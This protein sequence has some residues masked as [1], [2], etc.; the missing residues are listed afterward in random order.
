MDLF[1]IDDPFSSLDVHVSSK[2]FDNLRKFL[3]N[4]TT[5]ICTIN[6]REFMS[7]VDRIILLENGCVKK[8]GKPN[9]ILNDINENQLSSKLSTD[10]NKK[11]LQEILNLDQLDNDEFKEELSKGRVKMKVYSTYLRAVG[12]SMAIC[13]ILFVLLMQTSKSS[14]DYWLSYWVDRLKID[15]DEN[16]FFYLKVFLII[17]IITNVFAAFRSVLFAIGC[18][19][20]AKNLYIRL[21]NVIV[22]SKI[23][24][25][26]SRTYGQIINRLNSDVYH[27]DENLPFTLNL[28]LATLFALISIIVISIYSVPLSLIILLILS[29][30]YYKTQHYYR[31]GSMILK[32]FNSNL[33]SPIF[34]QF[35]ETLNGLTTIRSFNSSER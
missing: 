21:Y 35:H 20:G 3:S 25:F 2:V 31:Y 10:L 1:L 14:N 32:R 26:N 27:I 16:T 19:Q 23:S 30:P 5:I 12:I 6:Q 15:V 34:T 13:V 28:F 11:P 18:I 8:I 22:G 24:F 33:L 29:V 9:E 7:K 17:V 4:N